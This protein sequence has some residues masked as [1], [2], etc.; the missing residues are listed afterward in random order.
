M[1]KTSAVGS[2]FKLLSPLNYI[3]VHV[4]CQKFGMSSSYEGWPVTSLNPLLFLAG[5][6]WYFLCAF[7]RVI[8]GDIAVGMEYGWCSVTEYRSSC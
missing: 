5:C 3:S 7:Q 8:E 6:W 4:I 1:F 2:Y